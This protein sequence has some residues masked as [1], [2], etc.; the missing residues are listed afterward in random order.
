[1]KNDTVVMVDVVSDKYREAIVERAAVARLGE[2]S[3]D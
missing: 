1:M 2:G 3:D